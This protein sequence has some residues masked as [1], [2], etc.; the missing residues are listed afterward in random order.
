MT[1]WSL[2][3][4]TGWL[5]VLSFGRLGSVDWMLVPP[6]VY[7][8]VI[9]LAVFTALITFFIFQLSTA[10]IGP[11]RVVSYIYVNPALVLLIGLGFGEP[12]RP[13][14]PIPLDSDRWRH[15]YFAAGV[16]RLK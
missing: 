15:C 10:L 11:T 6:A 1:F 4:G 3:T 8:G 16:G 5:L 9:Y 13:W 2:D 7:G 14:R 12:C